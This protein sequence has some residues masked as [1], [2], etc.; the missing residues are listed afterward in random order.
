MPKLKDVTTDEL[1]ALINQMQDLQ[2]DAHDI[3]RRL[4]TTFSQK[5]EEPVQR[6]SAVMAASRALADLAAI[7]LARGALAE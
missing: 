2:G 7:L 5:V 6:A 3:T 4:E 1:K